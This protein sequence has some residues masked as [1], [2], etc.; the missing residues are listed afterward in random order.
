MR[1]AT[2][3]IEHTRRQKRLAPRARRPN[4]AD[5][6]D[7]V[8][9]DFEPE[10]YED[11]YQ[12]RLRAVLDEKVKGREITVSRPVPRDRRV[13]DLMEALKESMKTVQGRDKKAEQ[14]KRKKA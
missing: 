9:E 4:I 2:K 1:R 7:F 8:R 14:T 10:N 5:G 13:I 6:I 11:E 12:N 3:L